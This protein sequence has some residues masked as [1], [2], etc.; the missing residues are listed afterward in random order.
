MKNKLKIIAPIIGIMLTGCVSINNQTNISNDGIVDQKITFDYSQVPNKDTNDK[1]PHTLNE[2]CA[3]ANDMVQQPPNFECN[4]ENTDI[5]SIT[6]SF[7]T[8][9]TN[10]TISIDKDILFAVESIMNNPNAELTQTINLP[11]DIIS[12]EIG[13][14]SGNNL[15]ITKE[16]I[17]AD[18]LYEVVF[19][20]KKS[21]K[22]ISNQE[23][24]TLNK[25]FQS[26]KS[27]DPNVITS[28]KRTK[29]YQPEIVIYRLRQR[30]EQKQDRT[31]EILRN[32][33]QKASVKK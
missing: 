25:I 21:T 19:A 12:S 10:N 32:F 16:E 7:E 17:N 33:F 30:A 2:F 11:G 31:P 22:V 6:R 23:K 18:L 8:D 3:E 26:K 29:S 20:T 28:I 24:Q 14:I 13:T 4:E 27:Y 15:T 9:I 5:Y 1:I